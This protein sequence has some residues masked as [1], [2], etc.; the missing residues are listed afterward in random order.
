MNVGNFFEEL[1]VVVKSA[2]SAFVVIKL[3]IW[4]REKRPSRQLVAENIPNHCKAEK[5]DENQE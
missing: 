5:Q 4:S 2:V 1:D 3:V